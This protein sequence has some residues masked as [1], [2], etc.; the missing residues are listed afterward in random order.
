MTLP[1][2]VFFRPL[3][4]EAPRALPTPPVVAAIDLLPREPVLFSWGQG[5]ARREDH[6]T[7]TA[8][9][10]MGVATHRQLLHGA[11]LGEAHNAWQDTFAHV[12]TLIDGRNP[13]DPRS[14]PKASTS[15][16]RHV[17]PD[18]ILHVRG[19]GFWN[20][21]EMAHRAGILHTR[22]AAIWTGNGTTGFAPSITTED[23]LPGFTAAQALL[24]TLQ[25]AAAQAG[26]ARPEGDQLTQAL[27]TLAIGTVAR[28]PSA[29][30]TLVARTRVQE[31][32]RL[33]AKLWAHT[34]APVRPLVP[35]FV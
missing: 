31:D 9:I 17:F 18:N 30:A 27:G 22:D 5:I 13:A 33:V 21:D 3:T 23:W 24:P 2:F 35:V 14:T 19:P 12:L 1:L 16:F 25:A 7:D 11:T 28:Q 6:A 32:C 26:V 4:Q 10:T 15:V 20:D 29:H 34:G 8:A